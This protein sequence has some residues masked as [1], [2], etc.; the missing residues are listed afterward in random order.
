MQITQL[1]NATIVVRFAAHKWLIDPMLCDPGSLP[2]FQ[3]QGD[4]RRPNPLVPPP[5]GCGGALTGITAAIITH[6]HADHIDPVAIAWLNEQGSPAYC[7]AMDA[8][9]LKRKGLQ[10]HALEDGGLGEPIELV[11]GVHGFGP[12]GWLMGPVTGFYIAPPDEP[13]L[14]ITGDTVLTKGVRS[15]IERLKPQVI[16]APAGCANFGKGRDILFPEEEIAE[17]VRIAPGKVILNHLEALD[18]CPTTRTGLRTL[19]DEAGQGPKTLIPS[20]GETLTL[21]PDPHAEHITP[22]TSKR[23]RGGLQKWLTAK[24]A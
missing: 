16:V 15:A 19:V 18:H 21:N 11:P 3:M 6:V 13:S 5:S 4:N 24:I 7:R 8:A 2:G 12:V 10:T 22:G 1:R 20:D 17:L 9:H 23:A 14:Y